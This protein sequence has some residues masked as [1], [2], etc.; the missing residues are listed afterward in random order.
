MSLEQATKS[1][2]LVKTPSEKEQADTTSKEKK[3]TLERVYSE[4]EFRKAQSSWDRQVSLYKSEADKVSQYTEQLEQKERELKAER[5]KYDQLV[6]EQLEGDPASLK[7]YKDEKTFASR[8]KEL[9]SQSEKI[10][11]DARDLIM[12]RKVNEVMK[13]FGIPLAELQGAK[14]PMELEVLGLRYMQAHPKIDEDKEPNFDSGT[15]S[16]GGGGWRDLS[17][18]AKIARALRKGK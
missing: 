1:E 9:K 12:E 16:G 2:E 7:R 10:D 18:D 4:D 11:K 8:E 6:A 13:E 14:S 3:P 17:P 15:S 5:E